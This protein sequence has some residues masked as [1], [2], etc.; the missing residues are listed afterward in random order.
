LVVILGVGL[1]FGAFVLRRNSYWLSVLTEIG[2]AVALIAPLL[3][4]E[5]YLARRIEQAQAVTSQ[6]VSAVVERVE[7]VEAEAAKLAVSLAT[8]SERAG[9]VVDAQRKEFE[10]LLNNLEE[11][12][13]AHNIFCLVE[14]AKEIGAISREGVRVI[15]EYGITRV[16]FDTS[17]D[18]EPAGYFSE[19]WIAVPKLSVRLE[20]SSGEAIE[21]L[22]W[23]EDMIFDDVVVAVVEMFQRS[24]DFSP[25]VDYGQLFRELKD[26]LDL[27]V[28]N[29][30]D[31]G[32]VAAPV[33]G[34]PNKHWAISDLGL[35]SVNVLYQIPKQ[36]L[37]EPDWVAHMQE[38]TWVDMD[39]FRWALQEAQQVF[40]SEHQ[41]R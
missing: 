14:R 9:R 34:M 37:W 18:H 41:P 2:G 28:H 5:R 10:A 26:T 15:P 16:R 29:R 24:R 32:H 21:E 20:S 7:K 35:E 11:D 38:K 6:S 23:T 4:A 13:T 25:S 19:E 12:F 1:L 31:N 27:A 40:R 17:Y 30:L 33:I 36:R 22:H 3:I 8:L 39:E